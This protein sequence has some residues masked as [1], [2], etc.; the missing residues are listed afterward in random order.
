MYLKNNLIGNDKGKKLKNFSY[1]IK[2]NFFLKLMYS[3]FSSNEPKYNYFSKT[4]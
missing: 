4:I 2:L 3:P 1:K